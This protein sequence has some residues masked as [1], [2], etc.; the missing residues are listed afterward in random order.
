MNQ[1]T[2]NLACEW[3]PDGI[4]VNAV[5]PYYIATPLTAKVLQDKE[6]LAVV[7]GR[8]ALKRVGQPKE[9]SGGLL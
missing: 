2:K 4:H 3:G 1:L 8:T 7:E 9:I 5:S 6:Y